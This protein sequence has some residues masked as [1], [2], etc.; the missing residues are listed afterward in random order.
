MEYI[1]LKVG[2]FANGEQKFEDIRVYKRLPKGWRILDGTLTQPSGYAWADNKERFFIKDSNGKY[3]KNEKY[4]TAFVE[5][6]WHK[7]MTQEQ[8][9]LWKIGSNYEFITK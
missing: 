9:R 4:E 2:K 8:K 6:G 7:K 5:L 3:K 1:R